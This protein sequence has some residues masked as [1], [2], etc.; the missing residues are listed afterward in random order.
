MT[1]NIFINTET[2]VNTEPST[3]TVLVLQNMATNTS[4]SVF[5]TYD[6]YYRVHKDADSN[7]ELNKHPT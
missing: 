1:R 5:I 3:G 6:V 7:Y 2:G 4:V